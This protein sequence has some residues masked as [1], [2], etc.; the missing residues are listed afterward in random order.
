MCVLQ[1][2]LCSLICTGMAHVQWQQK[3]KKFGKN[4][5]T[6][7]PFL[8]N[9]YSTITDSS[10]KSNFPTGKRKSGLEGVTKHYCGGS[11][12]RRECIDHQCNAK[13][14]FCLLSPTVPSYHISPWDIARKK[15]LGHVLAKVGGEKKPITISN[16]S[17]ECYWC[18]SKNYLQYPH[19]SVGHQQVTIFCALYLFVCRALILTEA[20]LT[21][22]SPLCILH[23]SFAIANSSDCLSK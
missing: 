11:L 19:G 22:W 23:S 14:K 17:L 18:M 8:P 16:K 12:P 21:C 15:C 6:D 10:P 20:R 7:R 9:K 13:T 4:A 3:Q 5:L 1:S 2:G